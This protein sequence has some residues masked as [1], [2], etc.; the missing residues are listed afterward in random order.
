MNFYRIFG[1]L[2]FQPLPQVTAPG[3]SPIQTG[4]QIVFGIFGAVAVLIITIAGFQFVLSRGDPQRTATAR[5]TII[6]AVIGLA[7]SMSAF[8]VVTFMIGRV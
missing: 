4:L 7:V 3:T 6:Y 1:Q 2:D 5:N 8:A